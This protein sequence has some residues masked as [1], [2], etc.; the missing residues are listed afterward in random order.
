MRRKVLRNGSKKIAQVIEIAKRTS[1]QNRKTF[2]PREFLRWEIVLHGKV[3]VGAAELVRR[4]ADVAAA[5]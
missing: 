3:A 4:R 5:P 1:H 2:G